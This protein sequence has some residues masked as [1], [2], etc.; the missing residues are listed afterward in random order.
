VPEKTYRINKRGRAEVLAFQGEPKAHFC[1]KEDSQ[2]ALEKV[3]VEAWQ[4]IELSR[5]WSDSEKRADPPPD[6][7]LRVL[8]ARVR[9][10]SFAWKEA[11]DHLATNAK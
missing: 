11:L 2:L 6:R 5:I 1:C 7:K 3:E 9:A 10:A 4:A 8:F